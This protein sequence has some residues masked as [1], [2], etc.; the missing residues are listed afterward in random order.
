MNGVGKIEIKLKITTNH[1]KIIIDVSDTGKGIPKSKIKK[2]FYPGYTTKKR[3]WGLGLTLAKRIIEDYHR[4][5]IFVKSSELNRGTKFRIILNQEEPTGTFEKYDIVNR[6]N[7]F[8]RDLM[9]Q[10]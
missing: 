1:K 5:T 6:L 3:G 10:A 4:G 8:R 2:V 7:P 9:E